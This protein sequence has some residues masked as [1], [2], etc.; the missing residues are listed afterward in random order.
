M[1]NRR[2][3]IKTFNLIYVKNSALCYFEKKTT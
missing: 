2:L 3:D 1:E